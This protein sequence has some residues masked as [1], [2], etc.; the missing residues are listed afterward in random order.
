MNKK[1]DLFT[2]IQIG[3]YTLRNRIIMAPMTRNRADKN[4][5]PHDLNTLY[6]TQRAS[7]GLI[8]TEA[9]QISPQG[10]GYPGTPGIYSPEQIA[11]WKKITKAVHDKGGRI[12]IQLWH[13]GR[14]SH[15]SLQPDG[16][17]PVAP[18]A[19]KPEGQA[20]TYTGMQ[21]FVE[22]RALD[23]TELP[24]IVADYVAAARNAMEAGFDGVEVHAA[25]GYL[26]DEFL[27]DGS[28]QRKDE[29]GG[30]IE[31]RYRLLKEVMTAVCDAIGPDK[32]GV[33]ISPE[34]K[35][36]DM[37]DSDAQNTFNHVTEMLDSFKLAYLHVLEGDMPT[38]TR[39]LD[40]QQ[41]KDRFH[42]P[43]MAN[44]AY[45]FDKAQSVIFN[46]Q[47]DMVSFGYLYIGNPD[48]VE[49]F[50]AGAELIQADRSTFYG[51]DAKGYTDYPTLA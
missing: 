3:P 2:P 43:Y 45:D 24:G 30:S 28:N 17:L 14:I 16:Q 33:R 34:N 44:C 40:Y 4:N 21:D 35:F 15:P 20:V 12:F 13:V 10:V 23:K 9:A 31:N 22:P 7:A 5:A 50:K 42:G 1:P 38:K 11:G 49:R 18:S 6:Y 47:A 8:I 26:L 41:I 37:H 27:R 39:E 19:I 46:N 32:V 36:N 48:L 51:G 29:Y 25:N